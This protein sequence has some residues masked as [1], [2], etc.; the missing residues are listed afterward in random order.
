MK[1]AGHY[2]WEKTGETYHKL[3][4]R[5]LVKAVLT[6]YENDGSIHLKFYGYEG[7]SLPGS[8]HSSLEAAVEAAENAFGAGNIQIDYWGLKIPT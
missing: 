5:G 2:A 8:I 1:I 3:F 4:L 6:P 7:L